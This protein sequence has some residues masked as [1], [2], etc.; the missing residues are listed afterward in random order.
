MCLV[1]YRALLGLDLH[2]NLTPKSKR[3]IPNTKIHIPIAYPKSKVHIPIPICGHPP[4]FK[5][6]W[7]V[8]GYA[9]VCP[10]YTMLCF[11]LVCVMFPKAVKLCDMSITVELLSLRHILRVTIIFFTQLEEGTIC[12]GRI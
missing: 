8:R 3:Y 1:I 9:S 11:V 4:V 2:P 6:M 10:L 12:W 7:C 5:R